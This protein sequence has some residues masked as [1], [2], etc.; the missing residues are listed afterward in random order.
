[1]FDL[2]VTYAFGDYA[3]G[4]RI[5]DDAAIA[6]ILAEKP[7]FVVKVPRPVVDA[8]APV[9]SSPAQS[10]AAPPPPPPPVG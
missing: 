6:E 7:F 1:M 10:P 8:P 9:A 2:V 5:T 4:A 3:P